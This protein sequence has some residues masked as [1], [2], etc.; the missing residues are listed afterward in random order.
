M[1]D[2][3]IDVAGRGRGRRVS[4][5]GR[6]RSVRDRGWLQRWGAAVQEVGDK[7]ELSDAVRTRGTAVHPQR[8]HMDGQAW[9]ELHSQ[10]VFEVANAVERRSS[11]GYDDGKSRLGRDVATVS[12]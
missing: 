7:T 12:L 10:E 9:P 2:A 1:D 6:R 11:K 8:V 3:D 4:Q 5:T